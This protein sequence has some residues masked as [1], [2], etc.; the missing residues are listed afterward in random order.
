MRTRRRIDLSTEA[1]QRFERGADPEAPPRAADRA[2]RLI[3]EW[4][5]G[6]VLA[7][8]IDVG[9]APSR[10]RVRI[11]PA[12]ASLVV[13]RELSAPAV[14]ASLEKASMSVAGTDEVLE[15]EVPGF[16][17]DVSREEDLI[18]E[19][20]RV[21]G[22]DKV[23]STLPSVRQAGALG[24]RQELRRRIRSAAVAAGL[25]EIRSLSFASSADLETFGGEPVRIANPLAAEEGFLRASLL[26]GMLRALSR[27]LSR[28]LTGAALF[29][30]GIVFAPDDPVAER[31]RLGIAMTGSAAGS[32]HETDRAF[33]FFDLKGALEALLGAVGVSEWSLQPSLDRPFHPGRSAAIRFGSER[34]GS[35]GELHRSV[36]AAF[37]LPGRVAVAE[38]EVSAIGD[39]VGSFALRDVPRFPP[40]RR[41][42]AFV[43]DAS[44]AAADVEAAIRN[45]GGELLSELRLFDVFAGAPVAEGRRSL[46]FAVGFRAPDRTLTDAEVDAAVSAVV[47][48]LAR[49]FGA[50]L[51]S[52]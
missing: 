6:T 4:S 9:G 27:N 2:A 47:E 50:E 44:V 46:A 48:R 13:G 15:A 3:V 14:R 16:R 29:E 28:Q 32:W 8:A 35:M 36:A 30:V 37:D 40:V 12:R 1:S 26:P 41:D 42:L 49:D 20:A 38:L 17:V 25:R 45:A 7:G 33:D 18:E 52:G 5:G 23:G 10:R 22:Y 34:A 51:R 39:A 21:E 43:L 11:R 24:A 19:V 31:E